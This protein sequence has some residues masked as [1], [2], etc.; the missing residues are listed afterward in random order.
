MTTKTLLVFDLD[1]TLVTTRAGRHAFNRALERV[2]GLTEAAARVPMAGRTDPEIFREI[3]GQH[4]LDPAAFGAWKL[5]FLADLA[6]QLTHDPGF[7]H[8]GVGELL[9]FCVS[10]DRFALALGTGNVEEGARMKL[11]PH[12]LNRYFPTGGFGE[13]GATRA[14][15]IARAIDRSEEQYGCKF[16]RVLVIGD[17]PHD[18]ACGKANGCL[19]V[20]VATGYHSRE[21]LLQ[22]GADLVLPDLGA[23]HD[24]L[25]RFCNL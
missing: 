4:G 13:D 21:E 19:T 2:F 17:T 25:L 24:V 23:V 10:D 9:Q 1:G 18:I 16:D 15:L 5:E 20:G 7:V 14:E 12:D 22:C 3:C 11:A 8:P 6:E